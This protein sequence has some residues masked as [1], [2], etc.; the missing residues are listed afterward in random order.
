M[1]SSSTETEHV[2]LREIELH[3]ED[4]TRRLIYAD[5]LDEQ[6]DPRGEYLRVHCELAGLLQSDERYEELLARE[7]ELQLQLAPEWLEIVGQPRIQNCEASEAKTIQ[8]DYECPKAWSELTPTQDQDIRHC[9]TCQQEVFRCHS[10]IQ[11]E[12]NVALGRCVAVGPELIH[13]P[14]PQPTRSAPRKMGRMRMGKVAPQRDRKND[15]TK[16]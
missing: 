2:F 3:P 10:L 14:I 1:T 11:L 15:N 16:K 13:L 8:F 7:K 5:W 9:S 6:G 4:N 12:G